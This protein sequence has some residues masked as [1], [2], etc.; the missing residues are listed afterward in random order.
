MTA[1]L[2]FIVRGIVEGVTFSLLSGVLG[3]LI[4]QLLG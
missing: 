1:A 3:V 2:R 4:L